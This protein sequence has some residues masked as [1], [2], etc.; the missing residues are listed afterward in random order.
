MGGF[1][2]FDG[3]AAACEGVDHLVVV[4]E[5]DPRSA[6]GEFVGDSYEVPVAGVADFDLV[7]PT[8]RGRVGDRGCFVGVDHGCNGTRQESFD[9][10]DVR[11]TFRG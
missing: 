7:E 11:I 8:T 1:D 10:F 3:E 9:N 4:V 5:G 2:G 6:C